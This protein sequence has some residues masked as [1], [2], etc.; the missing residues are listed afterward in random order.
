[1]VEGATVFFKSGLNPSQNSHPLYLPNHCTTPDTETG[2]AHQ[3]CP[4]YTVMKSKIGLG[5]LCLGVNTTTK[6]V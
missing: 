1:M 6:F 3:F 4:I 2:F 5:Q